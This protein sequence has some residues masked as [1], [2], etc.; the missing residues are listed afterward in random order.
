MRLALLLAI[1]VLVGCSGGASSQTCERHSHQGCCSDH[2][3]VKTYD[4]DT[5]RIICNDGTLSPTCYW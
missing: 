4:P 3:G 2:G 5:C 1:A